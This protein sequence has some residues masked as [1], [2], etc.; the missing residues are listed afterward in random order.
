MSIFYKYTTNNPTNKHKTALTE[1]NYDENCWELAGGWTKEGGGKWK[2]W[3]QTYNKE[4]EFLAFV[5]YVL[6]TDG[7]AVNPQT[8]EGYMEPYEYLMNFIQMPVVLVV[9]LLGVVLVLF[10]I[11]RTIFKK[12]FDKGI[13]FAGLGTVFTVLSLLLTAGYNNTA[14]YPSSTDLQSSLTLANSCS[15]LFTLEVMAYVSL[16]VPFVIA[17]IFYAWRSISKDKIDAE[18]MNEGGHA[19]WCFDLSIVLFGHVVYRLTVYKCL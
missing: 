4:G 5:G 6:L 7:Y 19:Y 3:Q 10:G 17:Y 8:Q 11:G 9:F 14:Y 1:D 13:W 12:G 2:D 16:L 15:S 18:E